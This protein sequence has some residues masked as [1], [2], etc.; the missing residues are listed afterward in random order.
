MKIQDVG[1]F[2]QKSGCCVLIGEYR[3]FL[4]EKIRF[5]DKKDGKAKSFV[6]VVH[7]VELGADGRPVGAPSV[8][9]STGGTPTAVGLDCRDDGCRILIA[10]SR[11]GSAELRVAEWA[12]GKP[13]ALARLLSLPSPAPLGIAPALGG[14]ELILADR[15]GSEGRVRR[16]LIDWK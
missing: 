2:A 3:G 11:A 15:V 4:A 14:R 7:L 1:E 5:V 10:L 8:L 6:S 9:A 12:R 16:M 13:T